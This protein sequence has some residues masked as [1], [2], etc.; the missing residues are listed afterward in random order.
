MSLISLSLCKQSQVT[1]KCP[2]GTAKHCDVTQEQLDE[3]SIII[4]FM[5]LYSA[6]DLAN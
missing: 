3:V 5:D 2:M 1:L 4:Q 6:I